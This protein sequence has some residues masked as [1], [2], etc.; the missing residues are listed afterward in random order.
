MTSPILI[1][2]ITQ[3]LSRSPRSRA[4]QRAGFFR[5]GS[6]SG[7]NFKSGPVSGSKLNFS[8][9]RKKPGFGNPGSEI[10]EPRKDLFSSE[11]NL[12]VKRLFPFSEISYVYSI[13]FY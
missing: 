11:K 1:K 8:P 4:R 2:K 13:L 6:V 9:G 10:S 12:V 5:A 3:N 7:L